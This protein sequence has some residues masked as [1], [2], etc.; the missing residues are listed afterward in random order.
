MVMHRNLSA[1]AQNSPKLG[2]MTVLSLQRTH[3]VVA[4]LIVLGA[5]ACAPPT[6]TGSP[7]TTTTTTTSSGAAPPPATSTPVTPAP[8]STT[9]DY[10]RIEREVLV[11]LNAVRANPSAYAANLSAL[12]PLFNGNLIKK[13][14]MTVLI[15]TNEGASAVREAIGALQRQSPMSGL[16]LSPGMSAAA[17][18]LANDQR[19]T[20]NMGHTGSDGS[21]PGSRLNAHGSWQ[22]TYSENVDYGPFLTGRDVVVDLLVDDGVPDRGHRRNIFDASAHV[23]GIACGP[24]PKLRS[25]CVIDQAYGY[26]TR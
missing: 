24:H 23:V 25:M 8:A 14:G 26:G 12:L 13:P 22:M 21:N 18:D 6:R 2:A 1:A 10:R 11:E 15:R 17:A 7:T 5:T 16:A 3:R 19:Q 9:V 20:G 4:A